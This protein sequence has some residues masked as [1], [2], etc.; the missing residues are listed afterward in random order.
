MTNLTTI[1]ATKRDKNNL[2]SSESKKY[3][4]QGL[5]PGIIY[6]RTDAPSINVLFD[7]KEM[8]HLMENPSFRSC[9]FELDLEGKKETVIVRDLQFHP[10]T[11]RLLHIDFMPI[12]KDEFVIVKIPGIIESRA[13]FRNDV[14]VQGF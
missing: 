3:R 12:K 8:N 1:K 10:I 2:G 14:S 7:E 4:K 6:S 11:D 13:K 9:F 5:I